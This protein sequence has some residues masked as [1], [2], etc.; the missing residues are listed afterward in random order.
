METIILHPLT[1]TRITFKRIYRGT[2]PSSHSS[3]PMQIWW[4]YYYYGYIIWRGWVWGV[5]E[6]I[7]GPIHPQSRYIHP[8][9]L[10]P[11]NMGSFPYF[12]FQLLNSERYPSDSVNRFLVGRGLWWFVMEMGGST[13]SSLDLVAA[14]FPLSFLWLLPISTALRTGNELMQNASVELYIW[15]LNVK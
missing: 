1:Q 4:D 10:P 13:M 12:R 11:M 14:L 2:R 6:R 5:I 7:H 8:H 15:L 9:L 3:I